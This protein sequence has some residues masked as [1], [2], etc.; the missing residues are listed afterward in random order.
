MDEIE[1]ADD[2]IFALDIGTRSVIGV[3]GR[4]T[5]DLLEVE[6]VAIEEYKN[7]AVVDGQIED[8]KETAKIARKVKRKLEEKLGRSLTQV[9]IAAAGRVLRTQEAEHQAEIPAGQAV[10]PVFVAK[11]EF[12]AVQK[13]YETLA[14]ADENRGHVFFCVGHSAVRY[15]LDDYEIST[16]L[17]HKGRV[18]SVKVIATF[19]PKEVVESL[20]T[21]MGRIGLTVSGLT[22]EPIAAMN[23]VIPADL[24]KLNLALVDIG[25][26]TADIAVCDKGSVSA[27]TMVTVAG[28]EITEAIMAAYLVDFQTAEALKRAMGRTEASLPYQNILGIDEETTSA[29]LYQAIQPTVGHL[30]ETVTKKIL[31]I[32]QRPPAAV[33]L[34]GGGSQVQGLCR[35]VADGLGMDE[36]RVAVGGGNNMRRMVSSPEAVF[37]PEFATPVGIALT[38]AEREAGERFAVTVNGEKLYM[39]NSWDM[40]VMDALQMAGY[41]YGQIMGRAGKTL[42]YELNGKRQSKRGDFAQPSAVTRNGEPIS[43]GDKINPGDQLD[44]QPAIQGADAALLIEEAAGPIAPLPLTVNGAVFPAGPRVTVNGQPATPGQLI[45]SLDVVRRREIVTLADLGLELGVDGGI[46]EILVN[47]QQESGAY[48]L[49]QGDRIE[50]GGIKGD[51]RGAPAVTPRPAAGVPATPVAP[52]P[53]GAAAAPPAAMPPPGAVAPPAAAMSPPPV[54]VAPPAVAMSPPPGAVAAAPAVAMSPPPVAVASPAAAIPPPVAAPPPAVAAPAPSATVSPPA[55]PGNGQSKLLRIFL[56]GETF[57][58]PP[59]EDGSSYCFLDLFS[60]VDIDPSHPQGNLIQ[61]INGQEAPYSQY[62][63]EGD[64]VRVHWEKESRGIGLKTRG[65]EIWQ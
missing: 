30:A 58:L 41:K 59:K 11:L 4:K 35:L 44:F 38:A 19:L 65:Y 60:Y 1:Q 9:Y 26:G 40:T 64:Q 48:V 28:D 29:Q 31:E 13:A 27:Y 8:I 51:G 7:R 61:T 16:L 6:A 53:V 25:A 20:H 56:N 47:G 5:Q 14:G 33:F 22:L 10:E 42:I 17:G 36:H 23:A 24:R 45:R 46:Y 43:L 12:A 63:K 54:A 32:N 62:L 57:N 37:G 3:I 49:K 15:R 50:T 52:A 34:V 21:T 18:A 39:L 55:R 2:R